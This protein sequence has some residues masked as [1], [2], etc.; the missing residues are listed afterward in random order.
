MPSRDKGSTDSP[1]RARTTGAPHR[2]QLLARLPRP[3]LDRLRPYLE[4]VDLKRDQVL[5]RAYELLQTVYFPDTAVVA[6]M[7]HVPEGESLDVGLIGWDGVAGTALF[8]GITT[9][10][11]DG[12]V[13][14]PGAARRV[15]ADLLRQEAGRDESLHGAIGRYA[16]L[17]LARS[18]QIAACNTFHPVEHRCARWLLEAHDLIGQDE[19]PLTQDLLATA[20]GVRRPTVTLAMGTLA[21]A[22]LI[23]DERGRVS[24]RDRERLESASCGCY[25]LMR[26]A[27]RQLLGF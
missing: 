21:K 20:L 13:Q 8:P 1:N 18:M 5:F 15:S 16:Q 7:E 17:T 25:R 19:L 3:V 27:Q 2:N 14:I 6:L 12:V 26:D 23:Q 11:C 22:G 4:A 24:I 9:M 10:P